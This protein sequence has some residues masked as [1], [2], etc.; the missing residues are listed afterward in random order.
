MFEQTGQGGHVQQPQA[1]CVLDTAFQLGATSRLSEIKERP[2]DA[3]DRDAVACRAVLGM[4]APRMMEC[5]TL[6]ALPGVTRDGDVH[7]GAS[8][9]KEPPQRSGTSVT[10]ERAWAAGKYGSHGLP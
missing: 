3:R 5:D 9:V 6:D 4:D 1:L 10:Q 8:V 7:P 2:G